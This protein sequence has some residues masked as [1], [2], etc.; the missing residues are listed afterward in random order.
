[1]KNKDDV[2][3]TFL[4][5]GAAKAGTTSLYNY[6]SQHPQIYMPKNK[7]PHFF[8]LEGESRKYQGIDDDRGFNSRVTVW[9][10]YLE[11][12]ESAV[13]FKA[14]GE[15]ST[16][17]LYHPKAA[18]RIYQR[19]PNVKLIAVLRNPIDAAYS[20]FLHMYREGR[21][22]L[23]DFALALK[24]EEFR[25]NNHWAPLWHY[26]QQ[27]HYAEQLKRYQSYFPE[28]QLRVFLYED[29]KERPE[30]M[31]REIFSFLEVNEEFVP[32]LSKRYNQSGKP[33]SLFLH[34]FLTKDGSVLKAGKLLLPAIF[35]KKLKARVI[36]ANLKR[37][38][39]PPLNAE[40]ASMLADKF[41]C[42]YPLL[43]KM[44]RRDLSAWRSR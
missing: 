29:L 6:L 19:L 20:A 44:I 12:F 15:A 37:G 1:M 4:V 34:R 40:A 5:I 9:S 27:W 13:G 43:E 18:E 32:N 41:E 2:K 36:S 3:P 22:P 33:R 42:G 10:D 14:V 7:E 24:Q 23:H 11:L 38:E 8:A 17:Y 16:L 25:R 26:T 31:M 35:R 39:L 28:K 21:E 30:W